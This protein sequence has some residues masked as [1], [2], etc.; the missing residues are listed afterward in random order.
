MVAWSSAVMK[1]RVGL[2]GETASSDA[3]SVLEINPLEV[4]S[5]PMF[6]GPLPSVSIQATYTD[7]A[8]V[9]RAGSARCLTSILI[10]WLLLSSVLSFTV[11]CAAGTMLEVSKRIFRAHDA[12]EK[13]SRS[14]SAPRVMLTMRLYSVDVF[15]IIGF[16]RSCN[17]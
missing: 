13:H 6:W 17:Y 10:E 8:G 3:F 1:I 7:F 11:P 15:I 9:R 4:L 2:K 5:W 14:I 16:I 12:N